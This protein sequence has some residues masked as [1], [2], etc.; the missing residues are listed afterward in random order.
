[1]A[2]SGLIV[3]NLPAAYGV[4]VATYTKIARKKGTASTPTCCNCQ[5][6]EGEAANPS[7]YRGCRYAKEKMHKRKA[8]GTPNNTKGR[9]FSSKLVESNFSFAT[10]VLGQLVS[11]VWGH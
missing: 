2:T 6:A 9:V 11:G 4:G 1:L 5:L 8:Q 3:N 10:A 7:N